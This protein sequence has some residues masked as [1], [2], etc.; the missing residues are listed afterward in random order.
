MK[1]IVTG[2]AGFIGSAI[3]W[4]LNNAGIDDILIVDSLDSSDKWKNLAPLKFD[5]YID[6]EEFRKH[7]L[8]KSLGNKIKAIIHMGACSSTT[9]RDSNYLINNN[10]RYSQDLAKFAS[11]K[12]IRFIY[13]SSAATYGNGNKGY[14]DN[15][16]Q[17]EELRPLNI[18]GYSKHMF[19]LWIKR[20]D[21]LNKMVGLKFTNIFGP[22]EYH[23]DDMRSVVNKAYWQIKTTNKVKLFKSYLPE[24]KDG[25]Q[26]R[27]FLYI[28]DAV[29]MIAHF[30]DNN[31]GGI[32]NVGSSR[33]ET[34]NSLVNAVFKA[35]G[36]TPDIEYIEMPE[37][38]KDKYQ[39]Y[40]KADINKIRTTGHSVPI[41]S[42]E[43]AVHDY[44]TNYLIPEKH[45]GD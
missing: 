41:A 44:V 27:D 22:N 32:Y 5:D 38:L 42:L 15:E 35:L 13:A 8:A 40:T 12:N 31:L 18:Y 2:G 9:E 37:E 45:L 6:K 24:Y 20:N 4:K 21:L 29:A 26:K 11:I 19:D 23:K 30:L 17:L 14:I 25:E 3:V 1:Y 33:A 28:K 39:Y 43:H 36:K 10:Y 7:I 34:W 16:N